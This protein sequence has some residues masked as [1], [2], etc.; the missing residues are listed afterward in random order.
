MNILFDVDGV[1]ADYV[2]AFTKEASI[3][4]YL[5]EPYHTNNNPCWSFDHILTEKKQ[6]VIQGIVEHDP[7]WWTRLEPLIS[8]QLF[9]DINYLQV[10]NQVFFCTN[11][12]G[13]NPQQQTKYWLIVHGIVNPAVILSK[14]KDLVAE[15]LNI[16]YSIEDNVEKANNICGMASLQ[17]RKSYLLDRPY[18]RKDRI[19]SLRIVKTVEEFLDDVKR[20]A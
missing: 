1:L 17:S 10:L 6:A 11:R 14:R 15:A 5:Q 9:R 13:I 18:N 4:D 3:L 20:G 8:Q 2:F 19:E 7:K 12:F 16:D